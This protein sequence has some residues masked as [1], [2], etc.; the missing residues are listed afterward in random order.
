MLNI[1]HAN[2]FRGPTPWLHPNSDRYTH[3]TG[4]ETEARES[5]E[6]CSR[7]HS[8]VTTNTE[9]CLTLSPGSSTVPECPPSSPRGRT[10]NQTVGGVG[11]VGIL[12][13]K[14]RVMDESPASWQPSDPHVLQASPPRAGQMLQS[15]F[16][17]AEGGGELGTRPLRAPEK[18]GPAAFPASRSWDPAS[19][20]LPG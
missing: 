4:E 19:S 3:F 2:I 6:T 11:S 15:R 8:W 1:K 13:R 9:V 20:P 17:E 7:S 12:A 16:R 14:S 18:T 5:K 10:E